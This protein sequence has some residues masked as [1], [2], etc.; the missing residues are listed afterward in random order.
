[1]SYFYMFVSCVL[2]LLS[3]SFGTELLLSLV[4]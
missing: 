2:T 4:A 3:I 1:M